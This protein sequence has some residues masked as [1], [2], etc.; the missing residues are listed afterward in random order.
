MIPCTV[1][2][3]D[4]MRELEALA[5]SC[6]GLSPSR[7][8]RLMRLCLHVIG[9]NGSSYHPY[10]RR[11]HAKAQ[12]PF[13]LGGQKT[14]MWAQL[15]GAVPALL[16]TAMLVLVGWWGCAWRA[17]EAGSKKLAQKHEEVLRLISPGHDVE[18]IRHSSQVAVVL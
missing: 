18:A 11:A 4:W 6:G 8:D 10:I 3:T 12:V 17:H 13:V 1:C 14:T 15:G 16:L 9:H 2:G 7:V 5:S